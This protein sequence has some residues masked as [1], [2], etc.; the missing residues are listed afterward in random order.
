VSTAVEVHGV[1]H[2]FPARGAHSAGLKQLILHPRE[3]WKRRRHADFTALRN[4]DLRVE[5]GE[6]FGLVG[7]NGAGKSTLIAIISGILPPT[8]GRVVTR[9]RIAPLKLT[10]GM[11]PLFTGRENIML[12]GVLM[13]MLRSEVL[14]RMDEIVE[15]SGLGD[16]IEQPFFT[17]SLGMRM[18]LGFAVALH[19]LPDILLVDEGL[20]VGDVEFQQ[21]CLERIDQRHRAGMTLIIASHGLEMIASTCDRAAWLDAGQIRFLG[22]PGE[23]VQRYLAHIAKSAG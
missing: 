6:R 21:R 13:G 12:N 15:F 5:A 22:A 1:G 20:A 16:F 11:E 14:E 4:I 10:L 9:G 3:I 23:A 2:T 18:R 17:Y 19:A 8:R 7:N